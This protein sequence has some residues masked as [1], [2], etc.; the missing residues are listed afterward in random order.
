M[1]QR[2]EVMPLELRVVGGRQAIVEVLIDEVVFDGGQPVQR[3]RI[4]EVVALDCE[5]LLVAGLTQH[6]T[7]CPPAIDV[8][9][10][11]AS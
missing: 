8:S 9:T 10:H 1:H 4:V 6:I 7:P 5:A 11:E 2:R 3:C